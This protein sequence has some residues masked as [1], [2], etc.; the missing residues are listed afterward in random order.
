MSPASIIIV[1]MEPGAPGG[2][3]HGGDD[4]GVEMGMGLDGA[5]FLEMLCMSY[6]RS[7][8]ASRWYRVSGVQIFRSWYY[9]KRCQLLCH[10]PTEMAT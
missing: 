2:G 5:R 4:R 1:P 9:P 3:V 7:F 8:M 6:D 10:Q